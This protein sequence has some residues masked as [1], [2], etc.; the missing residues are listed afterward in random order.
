MLKEEWEGECC[1]TYA[2]SQRED[3]GDNQ[4]NLMETQQRQKNGTTE[5]ACEYELQLNEEMLVLLPLSSNK[6][7]AQ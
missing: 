4:E 7:L 3:G 5:Q 6:L 1:V 2:V